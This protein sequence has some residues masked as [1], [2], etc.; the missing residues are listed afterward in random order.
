MQGCSEAFSQAIGG[1]QKLIQ[2]AY[3]R[4]LKAGEGKGN[5]QL[6][7]L[8]MGGGAW[9]GASLPLD[10]ILHPA[11]GGSHRSR[12]GV[13]VAVQKPLST[14]RVGSCTCAKADDEGCANAKSFHWLERVVWTR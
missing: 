8:D 6:R 1:R 14:G 12:P 10:C 4:P 9:Q 5:G 11:P 7:Q 13:A 2:G 3:Q